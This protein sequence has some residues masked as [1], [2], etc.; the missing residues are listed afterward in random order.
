M[1][2]FRA[3]LDMKMLPQS[4]QFVK[5]YLL[6]HLNGPLGQLSPENRTQIDKYLPMDNDSDGD[7]L[8]YDNSDD[9]SVNDNINDD[10][11]D[12]DFDKDNLDG[13]KCDDDYDD[14]NRDDVISKPHVE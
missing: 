9:D 13:D 2:A 4:S 11:S 7:N 5:F 12:D 8:N 3:F 6:G 14:D 1:W 10:N